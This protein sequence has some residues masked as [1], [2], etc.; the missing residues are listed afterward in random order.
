[1]RTPVAKTYISRK[2]FYTAHGNSSSKIEHTVGYELQYRVQATQS[3]SEESNDATGL[4]ADS[5]SCGVQQRPLTCYWDG[6]DHVLWTTAVVRAKHRL[7]SSDHQIE[8]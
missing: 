4:Q 3:K 6:T 5:D 1:M 8:S 2:Q 7:R